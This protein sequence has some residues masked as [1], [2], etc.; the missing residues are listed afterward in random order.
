MTQQSTE[1]LLRLARWHESNND[2]ESAAAQYAESLV[3]DPDS[4]P[5]LLRLGTILHRL[6]RYDG[7]VD[8]FRR[9]AGLAP[10]S[11][12]AS[13]NLAVAL[14]ATGHVDEAVVAAARAAALAP[15]TAPI[16]CNY[17]DALMTQGS[18]AAARDAYRRAVE[19]DPKAAAA[20]NKLACAQRALG[21]Y[22]A[23][24]ASLR[25]A[26]DIAPAFGLALVNLGTLAALRR[27]FGWADRLL[28][29]ALALPDLPKDARDEA[30][31]AMDI[32]GEH[33]R[34][35]PALTG[36]VEHADPDRLRSA[37]V[38]T[39]AEFL[40]IIDAQFTRR[41][42]ALA[43]QLAECSD[44]P[45]F[46][47]VEEPPLFWAAFEAHFALHRSELP[48]DLRRVARAGQPLDDSTLAREDL[49][50]FERAVRQRRELAPPHDAPGWE[51]RLRYWHAMIGWHRPEYLPGQFKPVSNYSTATPLFPLVPPRAVAGTLRAFHDRAYAATPPGPRRAAL[52]ML[53]M[54]ECHA[55]V[56]ANGRTA[57]FLM[58]A[59]LEYAGFRPI[60][61][62]RASMARYVG[63]L[64]ALRAGAE[65]GEVLAI[66]AAASR[67][68]SELLDSV[69]DLP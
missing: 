24:G 30:V 32:L 33:E 18:Y 59:E 69:A 50:R 35:R 27:D 5:V 49:L 56:D 4:V 14:A 20:L 16:Q 17:G 46:V 61:L 45:E 25:K 62:S 44:P 23:A 41:Y 31:T 36:A 47:R 60:V 40:A 38:A 58:N 64:P 28:R 68:T 39:R 65:P 51:A 19:L 34:L 13:A 8:A 37:V 11:A 66:L 10:T 22:D 15:D 55:F 43:D 26:L 52:V 21:E 7:A 12:E 42:S 2:L 9:A 48:D 6:G 54:G 57:R 63:A 67:E 53:A 3:R 29:Q 1:P